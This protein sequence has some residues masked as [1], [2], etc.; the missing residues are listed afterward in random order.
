MD[1]NEL[2]HHGILGMKWGVRRYQ[3]KDGSLTPA[4]K[5]R[6]QTGQV[7]TTS[8]KQR[9]SEPSTASQHKT[10]KEMSDSELRERISRLELEKRYKDL[11]KSSEQAKT[12]KGKS[13]VMDVL[14]KSGKNIATQAVTYAMGS[15]VNKAVGSNVVNPKKGQKDK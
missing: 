2:M 5:R 13:F 6:L 3:N 4:G 8:D 1:N 7:G 15:I 9:S 10:V 14:E 11:S 12:S